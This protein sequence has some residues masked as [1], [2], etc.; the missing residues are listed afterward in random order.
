MNEITVEKISK[1]NSEGNLKAFAT[2]VVR[3]ITIH[4]LRIVQQ[5]NQEAWVSPPQKE[6]KDPQGNRKFSPIVQ[7]DDELKRAIQDEVLREWRRQG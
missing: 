7:L 3:G 6:W 5:P 4:D 1:I 2:V